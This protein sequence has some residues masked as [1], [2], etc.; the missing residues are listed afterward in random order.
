MDA[1]LGILEHLFQFAKSNCHYDY[2]YGFN[3]DDTVFLRTAVVRL[4]HGD[5]TAWDNFLI[6]IRRDEPLAR[7][8]YAQ[9]REIGFFPARAGEYSFPQ[10]HIEVTLWQLHDDE[11]D[12]LLQILEMADARPQPENETPR[13]RRPSRT[14]IM[15]VEEKPGLAGHARIGLVTFSKSRSSVYYRNRRLQT[16]NGKGYKRNFRNVESGLRYWVS[17][18]RRDGRDT[19]YPGMV[20]VDEEVRDEYWCEIRNAPEMTYKT[21]FWSPGKY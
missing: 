19:L 21:E 17:G 16:L 13:R 12:E 8:V 20:Y 7:W 11:R 1:K 15:Y 4:E 14:R 3:W 10:K 6:R 2:R 9:L 18:C 5:S